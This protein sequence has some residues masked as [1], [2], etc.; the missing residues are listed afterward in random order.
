MK[1][2]ALVLR[3]IKVKKKNKMSAVFFFAL[4]S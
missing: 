2:Q 4:N 1:H 3:K